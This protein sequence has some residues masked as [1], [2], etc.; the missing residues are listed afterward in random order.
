MPIQKLVDI[1]LGI[2]LCLGFSGQNTPLNITMQRIASFNT[3]QTRLE[4]GCLQLLQD[5]E[6]WW[7]DFAS[8]HPNKSK[9]F[10]FTDTFTALTVSMYNACSLILHSVLHALCKPISPS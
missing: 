4:E 10:I 1:M 3:R 9:N 5:L 7:Q 6:D 8:G 2:P